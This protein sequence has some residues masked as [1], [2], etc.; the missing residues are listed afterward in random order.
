MQQC[1]FQLVERGELA[2]VEEFEALGFFTKVFKCRNDGALLGKRCW[3][4]NHHL[5]NLRRRRVPNLYA[6]GAVV[7]LLAHSLRVEDVEEE[8]VRP[9]DAGF[10]RDE[11]KPLVV[12]K[13]V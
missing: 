13:L 5:S 11:A 4:R 7:N 12:E 9:R 6:R 10:L 8:L 1:F 3:E 2:L